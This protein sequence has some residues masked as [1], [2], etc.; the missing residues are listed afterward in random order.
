MDKPHVFDATHRRVLQW[1]RDGRV[2]GLRIDH[3][4][5]LADPRGYLDRLATATGSRWTVVEKILEPGERLLQ[6]WAT[7]GTT[8]YDAITAVTHLLLDPA[9]EQPL[10]DLHA[11]LTGDDATFEHVVRTAKREVV[12]TL[13]GSEVGRLGRDLDRVDDRR[14]TAAEFT[15]RALREALVEL[16]V[17]F[18]VYR[19]YV[20]EPDSAARVAHALRQANEA[21]PDLVAEVRWLCELLGS[22]HPD[23]PAAAAFV[24]RFEQTT[25]PVMAKGVEDTAFYR[26]LRLVALNEVGG[27]PGG[28]G[29]DVAGW[30]DH[31]AA[32]A[33][34][35][36]ASLTTLTTHDTK[37]SEDVRARLLVLAECPDDWQ[38]TLTGWRAAAAGHEPPDPAAGYLFWQTLVGA[39]PITVDR[40]T[41]YLVKAAREAKRHTSWIDQKADY[42]NRLAAFAERVMA[43]DGI[44]TGVEAFVDRIRPAARSNLLAQRLLQLT[45]PGVADVYQGQEVDDLSLVDPDNRRPVD[46]VARHRHLASLEGGQP[47]VGIGAEKLL[48]TSRA[49]RLR[50]ER[51]ATFLS[52]GYEPLHATGAA[53]DHVVA[54]RRGDD[55]VAVATRLPMGLARRG[56]W[57][58]TRLVLPS[59]R[60]RDL[61][62]GDVASAD[63]GTLLRRFPVAML[64]ADRG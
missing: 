16:L 31:C 53:A 20:G 43:D 36:P 30:H 23:D 50:R 32:M 39:W 9:G 3:P 11:E 40:L 51:P 44:T 29:L 41:A 52:G 45:M 55:V 12:E 48:L 38:A 61:L 6:S 25:G 60:W 18:D 59:G 5:G 13:F 8:G 28:F 58:E 64:V 54:Y 17:A 37:R 15:A 47:A 7:A 42:E 46:Y 14:E 63:L 26:Y 24:T 10:T 49:L 19:A 4:D 2:Q 34:R 35:W 27:D 21:R 1:L 62:T 56:G 22:A 33:E 57:G